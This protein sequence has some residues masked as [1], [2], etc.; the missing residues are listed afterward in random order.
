MKIL[1]EKEMFNHVGRLKK[2]LVKTITSF[3][4][5]IWKFVCDAYSVGNH[6]FTCLAVLDSIN[7]M[8]GLLNSSKL[9]SRG[10]L[11]FHFL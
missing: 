4:A 7:V 3:T 10:V 5:I 1:F 2:C 6:N 8:N 11:I 9:S